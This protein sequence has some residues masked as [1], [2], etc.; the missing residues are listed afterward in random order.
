MKI[1]TKILSKSNLLNSSIILN[2]HEMKE[3]FG[4][5]FRDFIYHLY[6]FGNNTRAIAFEEDKKLYFC[7]LDDSYDY[8]ILRFTNRYFTAIDNTIADFHHFNLRLLCEKQEENLDESLEKEIKICQWVL[9][10]P[11]IRL[12][13]LFK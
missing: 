6:I 12:K 10:H 7:L 13:R 3:I 4:D 1:S 11:S 9:N 5:N 2:E 8:K